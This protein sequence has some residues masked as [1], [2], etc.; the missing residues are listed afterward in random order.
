MNYMTIK[1]D[2]VITDALF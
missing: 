1:A 2:F